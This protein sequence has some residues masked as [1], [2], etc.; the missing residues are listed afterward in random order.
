MNSSSNG[1]NFQ[2]A[3]STVF[4]AAIVGVSGLA[5]DKAHEGALPRASI[6][7]GP[8]TPVDVLPQV[9]ALPAVVVSAR[10]T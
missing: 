10:R 7:V 8:L 1:F 6:E 9:V 4:A 3:L 5:L 2:T